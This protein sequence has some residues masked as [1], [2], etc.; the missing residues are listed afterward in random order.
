MDSASGPD[1]SKLNRLAGITQPTF[2]ANGDN[3]TTLHT[4]NSQ[5]LAE[6]LPNSELADL[7]HDPR[8]L[9]AAA[10]RSAPL[11]LQTRAAIPLRGVASRRRPTLGR[12][13]G[14]GG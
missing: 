7:P 2:I 9:V 13:Q 4:Q 11:P 5:L 1:A 10:L 3:D 6:H 8:A 14:L 12:R